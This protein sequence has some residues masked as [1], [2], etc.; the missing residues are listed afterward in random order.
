MEIAV[1]LQRYLDDV[2]VH[3]LSAAPAHV[4]EY[5]G[6][7]DTAALRMAFDLLCARHPVLRGRV[8]AD[9]HG[10]LLSVTGDHRAEFAE[11][12]GDEPVLYR[13]VFRPW[14]SAC[15]VARLM[16][17]HTANGGYVALR[18]DHAIVDG[19]SLREVFDQLWLIYAELRAGRVPAPAAARSLPRSP[20]ELLAQRWHPD[21]DVPAPRRSSS[22]K[23]R[24]QRVCGLR[25]HP[26]QGYLRLD[27]AATARLLDVAR[28]RATTVHALICGAVLV[29]H[30]VFGTRETG[31]A[32]MMCLSPVNLRH[33]VQPPV[34]AT[35]TTAFVKLH[36]AT[37]TV[38]QSRDPHAVGAE[39]KRQLDAAIR[40]RDLLSVAEL[41]VLLSEPVVTPVEARLAIVQV[42]NNGVVHTPLT[43]L[44]ELTITDFLSP[45][46][47]I[48]DVFPI[49][50]VY[51]YRGRLSI[52]YLY[53]S[54][55]FTAEDVRSLVETI[56]TLTREL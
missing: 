33:R 29:G 1:T 38:P 18:V 15:S 50:S 20:V 53:P 28:A 31:P 2:E 16:H 8:L 46:D 13:E 35:E 32:P 10:Y 43:R 5:R 48:L 42:S 6:T 21:V 22:T 25:V 27:E 52:R 12:G 51:T 19:H 39:V 4:A 24:F 17:V 55:A 14:N 34:G 54:N 41:P 45:V 9:E 56:A 40:R 44:G 11:F 30:C 23:D 47:V 3:N 7:V 26:R 36:P 37:V 49:Y